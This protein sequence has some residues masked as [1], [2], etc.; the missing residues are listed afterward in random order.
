MPRPRDA[1]PVLEWPQDRS[2]GSASPYRQFYPIRVVFSTLSGAP[3]SV[4]SLVRKVACRT[5]AD[6]DAERMQILPGRQGF[7]E[8]APRSSCPRAEKQPYS[9]NW[10]RALPNSAR[11]KLAPI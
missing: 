8:D 9:D 6:G 4:E 3:L 5:L 10:T 2:A 7:T 11:H 1:R